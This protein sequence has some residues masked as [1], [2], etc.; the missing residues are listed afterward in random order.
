MLVTVKCSLAAAKQTKKGSYRCVMI[1]DNAE[2]FVTFVKDMNDEVYGELSE[3]KERSFAIPD[4]TIL[5]YRK[6]NE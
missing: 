4:D 5:F 6:E 3:I 1:T 2:T